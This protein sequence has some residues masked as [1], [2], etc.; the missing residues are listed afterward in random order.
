ML[1]CRNIKIFGN[2]WTKKCIF[3]PKTVF[4][5]QEVHCCVIYIVFYTELYLQIYNYVQNRRFCRKNSKYL[6]DKNFTVILA[7][8]TSA[9]LLGRIYI[10]PSFYKDADISYREFS[11][12]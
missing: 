11:K 4:L 1:L 9:T 3:W 12:V 7:L 2:L 8:P 6:L 10:K 5:G